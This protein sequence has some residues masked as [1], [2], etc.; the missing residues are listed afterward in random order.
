MPYFGGTYDV[1]CLVPVKPSGFDKPLPAIVAKAYGGPYLE[2]WTL[3]VPSP[4]GVPLTS[5]G[6]EAI[7]SQQVPERMAT[8]ASRVVRQLGA[9]VIDQKG[10]QDFARQFIG[11]SGQSFGDLVT[12]ISYRPPWTRF[13]IRPL[14]V[15]DRL[16]G[17]AQVVAAI[18]WLCGTTLKF[19]CSD[20]PQECKLDAFKL[21][22]WVFSRFYASLDAPD[23]FNNCYF[24]GSALYASP[25]VFNSWDTS[26]RKSVV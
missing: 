5:Q 10:L 13:S 6:F 7:A 24:D 16:A 8:F 11:R 20:V 21:G 1:W 22:D 2:E 14:C 4:A 23:P 3:C 9:I 26:D 15:A 17:S 25:E 12:S 18:S 19:N